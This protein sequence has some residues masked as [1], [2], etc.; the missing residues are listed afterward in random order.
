VASTIQGVLAQRLVRRVC[1]SCRQ[2]RPPTPE[3]RLFL[4]EAAGNQVSVVTAAVEKAGLN[5]GRGCERCYQ[6]GYSGRIGIYELLCLSESLRQL[7]VTKSQ[8][9]SLRQQAIQ[10][11]M[12]SLRD[13][14]RFK[15]CHGFT[16]VAEILRATPGG[17]DE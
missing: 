1:S 6:S 11:G 5:V 4:N 9:S 8:T 12:Q 7:I 14:G 10:E 13:D 2:H 3:E 15:V 17:I 16:T